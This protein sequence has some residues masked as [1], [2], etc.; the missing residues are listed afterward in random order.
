ME[1]NCH[2]NLQ[3]NIKSSTDVEEAK[4]ILPKKYIYIRDHQS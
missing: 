2:K 4:F 1:L 3:L